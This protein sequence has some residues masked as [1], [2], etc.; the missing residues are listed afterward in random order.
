MY[1]IRLQPR[2]PGFNPWVGKITW[3]RAWQPTPA[4]LSGESP[5][6]EEP[7]RSSPWG[8][9]ESDM[10][11]RLSTASAFSNTAY[12]LCCFSNSWVN[13]RLKNPAFLALTEWQTNNGLFIRIYALKMSYKMS[14]LEQ[15]STLLYFF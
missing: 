6:T 15:H 14:Y 4:F 2:R 13:L 5:W 1:N 8:R 9:K 7:S 12:L 3:R 10:T 11:E